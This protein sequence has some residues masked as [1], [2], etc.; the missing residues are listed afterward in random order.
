[1]NDIV[2][3]LRDKWRHSEEDCYEAADEIDRLREAVFNLERREWDLMSE[4]AAL[5]KE[6]ADARPQGKEEW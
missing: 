2:E 4:V 6:L 1:M 5:E 3:R